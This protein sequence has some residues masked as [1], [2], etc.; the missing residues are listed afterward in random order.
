METVAYL[1]IGPRAMKIV[2][3]GEPGERILTVWTIPAGEAP[4]VQLRMI[5]FN[6]DVIATS[7]ALGIL[8]SG[9]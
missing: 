4:P 3:A 8:I 6:Q 5:R 7:E 9:I 2:M 1:T